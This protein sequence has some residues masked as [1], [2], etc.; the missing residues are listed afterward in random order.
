M[1]ISVIIIALN[2]SEF[3]QPCIKAVYPFVNRIKVQTNYDRSW[4]KE[5][6]IPDNTVE[7]ILEL[8]DNEGKI[9]LHISRMPDEAIARNW[10][11]RSDG[12]LLNHN[13]KSTTS[14][15][16][17]IT[18]FCE[19]SDYFWVIDGDEIYDPRTIPKILDYVDTKKPNI[20]K[21]RGINY[22]KKWNYQII[23]SDNFYQPGFIKPNVLFRENRN[24]VLP[25]WSQFIQRLVKNKYW[26]S[27]L[28]SSSLDSLIGI[29]HLPEEI[30]VFHHASYV[31]NDCRIEKKIFSSVHYE[32][33]MKIWYDNIWKKWTYQSKN[34]HPLYP[35]VFKEV[36]YVSTDKL[37]SSIKNEKWP[38]GYLDL[39]P[40]G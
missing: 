6:V 15:C 21:I 27:N 14:T 33:K 13:H 25:S 7:K 9:S 28:L 39:Q 36:K 19:D 1:K 29:T 18:D 16:E 35:D 31:G 26:Q 24:L 2:E 20:L 38:E 5:L 3:I 40:I 17:E 11:M 37:P 23:P 4:K 10:L 22:F 8:P 34:L 30:A 12:Y 32:E